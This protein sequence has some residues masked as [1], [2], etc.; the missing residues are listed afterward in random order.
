MFMIMPQK[1][2]CI[3]LQNASNYKGILSPPLSKN[4]TKKEFHVD[5]SKLGNVN[6]RKQFH[7]DWG[8]KHI[9]GYHVKTHLTAHGGVNTQNFNST[10]VSKNATKKMAWISY[11]QST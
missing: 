8:S 10:F 5:E 9:K 2:P 11:L 6:G 1:F 3:D 7:Q 4:I